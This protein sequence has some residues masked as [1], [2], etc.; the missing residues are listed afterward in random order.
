MGFAYCF[1]SGSRLP[2]KLA[3]FLKPAGSIFYFYFF[4]FFPAPPELL[5]AALVMVS[6]LGTGAKQRW[7]AAGV[8]L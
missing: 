2:C 5:F 7:D 8:F 1:C 6:V 4:I 3:V